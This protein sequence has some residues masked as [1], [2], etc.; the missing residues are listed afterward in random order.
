MN[1]GSNEPFDFSSL[2]LSAGVIRSIEILHLGLNLGHQR[3]IAVGLVDFAEHKDL[4]GVFVMDCDG[5]DR[6]ADLL[7]LYAA[8]RE[9]PGQTIV[10]KREKRSE[11]RSFKNRLQHV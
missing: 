10:A 3:A 5:E 9:H 4:D 1:D 2:R 11:G 6:P 8:T 7:E